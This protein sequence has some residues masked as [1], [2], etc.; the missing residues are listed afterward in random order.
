MEVKPI[1]NTQFNVLEAYYFLPLPNT[2]FNSSPS[3][4]QTIGY[5]GGT[6]D[7]IKLK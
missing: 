6:F 4:E 1:V 5:E 3:L 2:F 7:P